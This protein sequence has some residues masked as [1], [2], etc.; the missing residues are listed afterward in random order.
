MAPS[1]PIPAQKDPSKFSEAQR[2]RGSITPERSWWNLLHYDLELEI[3][4]ETKSLKGTNTIR[5]L[6]LQSGRK[7]QIDL[8]EPLKI[9]RVQ[10]RDR[11]L[12]FERTGDVYWITYPWTLGAGVSD[13]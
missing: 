5:F 9:T 10:Y 3:L 7:M 4:P 12:A 6:T 8:Q 2:L 11:D 1:I 13:E